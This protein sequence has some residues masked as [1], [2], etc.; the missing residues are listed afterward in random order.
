MN[1]KCTRC[2]RTGDERNGS[3]IDEDWYGPVCYEKA[4]IYGKVKNNRR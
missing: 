2:G 4:R 1:Q 3:Y